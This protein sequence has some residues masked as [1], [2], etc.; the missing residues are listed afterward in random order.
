MFLHPTVFVVGAGASVEFNMP[1][2]P[3]LRAR[4]GNALDFRRDPLDS[5]VGDQVLYH[6]LRDRFG[7]AVQPHY[8]AAIE[9]S[10]VIR[11]FQFES[12]DEVLHWFSSNPDIVELGKAAIVRE[13]LQAE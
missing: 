9:F 8:E 3:D 12:I 2:G 6:M 7:E 13:I 5:L 10:R 11:E 1:S 4:I